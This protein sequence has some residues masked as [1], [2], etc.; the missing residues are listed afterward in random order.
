MNGLNRP[1]AGLDL[2]PGSVAV[3]TG[4]GSGIGAALARRLVRDGVSVVIADVAPDLAAVATEIGAVAIAAD[5]SDQASVEALA[6]QTFD[7]F[8][9]VDLLCNN[10]G[11]G[12]PRSV[13]DETLDGWRR[14]ID[15][16]VF[17]VVHGLRAFLP[18]L[19]AADH[20]S[21]VLNTSSIAGI[22]R[23]ARW[24]AYSTT[25]FAI[26]GIS[27]ALTDQLA[28][29]QVG[30]SVLCPGPVDTP[31]G[32]LQHPDAVRPPDAAPGTA[33]GMRILSAD[34]VAEQAIAGVSAGQ[35]WIITDGYVE[36][37][38]TARLA[39]QRAGMQRGRGRRQYWR[40]LTSRN[41]SKPKVPPSRPRPDC[42]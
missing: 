15:V 4:G 7:R 6:E 8:G 5:V 42:L 18:R 22:H 31:M 40:L 35:F 12:R 16:N 28:G 20:P 27:E 37:E 39:A 36:S 23:N 1:S 19:L 3:V 10:A 30:I 11:I 25:K 24:I 41:S 29:T 21:H 34:E 17:G 13:L 26:V 38:L 2:G 32:P 9:R 14:M 33:A